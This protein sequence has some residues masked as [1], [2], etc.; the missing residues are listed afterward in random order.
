MV[1]GHRCSEL[2]NCVLFDIVDSL[3]GTGYLQSRFRSIVGSL[4]LTSKKAL[5]STK[6][7]L[8]VFELSRRLTDRTIAGSSQPST[9]DIDSDKGI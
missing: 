2:V 7:T 5:L 6:L 1:L 8:Q 3:P 9:T 4:L